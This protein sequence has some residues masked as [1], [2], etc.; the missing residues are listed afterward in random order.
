[1]KAAMTTARNLVLFVF[2][3]SAL[4]SFGQCTNNN[5]LT[6]AAVTPNCPGSTNI[7]CVQGGQ[8][9]LINVVNGNTYTFSTCGA[10]WDTQITL[11]NNAGGG[12]IGYNDDA[13]GL[14]STVTWTATFTGQLRVLVDEYNCANNTICSPLNITFK[15][16][17]TGDC[18]Y[19]LTLYDSFSDGWGTSNVGIS[20][21]AGTYQYYTLPAG[22]PSTFV[23]FGVNIGST[24]VL[25]YNNS[26]TWQTDNS[27]ILTL[28]GSSLFNSGSPPAAG[29]TYA[30]TV[31]CVP[32]PPPQEDCLGAMTICSNVSI[33]NN[34]NNTGN[35][36][37]INISNSGCLDIVEFQGTW[38]IFSPSAGG[39]LGFTIAPLGPDDYDWAVWGPY[40]PGTVP[41]MICPPAGPPIRCAA[42]SGPATFNSTGSY[43][44][45]MGHATYSPPAFASTAVS[46][47]IPATLDICPLIPPQYCGWV[48]GMQV[49]VG[50]VYLMYISNWSQS[51][52][53]FNLNWNLQNG[54]S[55]DCT[56]L[57]VELLSFDARATGEAVEL[58]WS[59]G[60]E[61]NSDRFVLERSRDGYAFAPIAEVEAVGTSAQTTH[62]GHMDGTPYAGHNYYRL[63]QVDHD[64]TSTH[65][66]LRSAYVA[67]AGSDVLLV[68]NPGSGR[69]D[70]LLRDPISQGELLLLDATGRA[71]LRASVGSGRLSFDAS[72]LPGGLYGYRVHDADG[73]IVAHG[74]W[75]R[76]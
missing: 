33:S 35:V 74:T 22:L 41:S 24:V 75:M 42:S 3:I 67:H 53:G 46:Y 18:V 69:V 71:V 26:G 17:P 37:D 16:P 72:A 31:T 59:T 48:P 51:S 73:R 28:G 30:A 20:I 54:A 12:S 6:G 64:G 49:T 44:T 76:E 47:G 40:P 45:G 56:L 70:V 14:Q 9:A 57:P 66:L 50:Q 25:S 19:T 68:P 11:Y 27:Y 63:R 15:A 39:N 52:M 43:A 29:V 1:M 61:V 5:T 38:Y 32:P 23:Q 21:N 58:T 2:G 13:C 62:Y 55:L 7:P 65:S 60:S 10:T 34:T 8:Y 4:H 36:A